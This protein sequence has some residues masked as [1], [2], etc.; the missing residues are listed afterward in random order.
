MR[1]KFRK[2]LYIVGQMNLEWSTYSLKKMVEVHDL[3]FFTLL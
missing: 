2:N 3:G 1:D